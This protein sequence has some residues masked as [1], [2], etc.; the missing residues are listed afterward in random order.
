MISY[1]STC[2]VTYRAKIN[3]PV[4]SLRIILDFVVFRESSLNAISLGR[5]NVCVQSF[6]RFHCVKTRA[7]YVREM[8]SDKA[9]SKTSQIYWAVI[10]ASSN[11]NH[12]GE[13]ESLDFLLHSEII[14]TW[15][16]QVE[17]TLTKTT[18]RRSGSA[19]IKKIILQ[20][21]SPISIR[22]LINFFLIT[23]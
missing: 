23:L 18:P 20:F 15:K 8:H 6:T 16:S 10:G 3:F 12:A 9:D 5:R 1:S 11:P 21:S 7:S 19:K 17:R 14:F 13:K 2:V 4:L 22:D